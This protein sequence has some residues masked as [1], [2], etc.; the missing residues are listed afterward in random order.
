[1]YKKNQNNLG[2][3]GIQCASFTTCKNGR[4]KREK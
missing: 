3:L 2:T 4:K 1:M